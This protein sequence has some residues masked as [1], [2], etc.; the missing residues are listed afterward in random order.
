[1]K[2]GS[3]LLILAAVACTTLLGGVDAQ[4]FRMIQNSNPGRTSSGARVTC[5]DPGGFTHWTTATIAWRLNTADQGGAAGV[6]TALQ[7]AMTAWN[8]VSPASYTLGDAGTTNAGFV[9]DGINTVLWANGNGCTG[10]CLAITALVLAP[11]QVI[12]EADVSFNRSATWNTNGSDYDV[13]AVAAHELGHTLGI[14]HTEVRKPR[15]R[16]TMYAYYFGTAGRTLENDDRDALNCAYDRYPPAGAGLL[17]DR[18]VETLARPAD[19]AGVR[20]VARARPGGA[21][22]RF[23]LQTE[24]PVKLEVFDVAGRHLTTLVSGVRAAGEHEVAWDGTTG[25]GRVGSGVY[26]ARVVSP[27]G[28]ANATVILAE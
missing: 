21:I 28:K 7:A 25:F 26:F 19:Q 14:H 2:N 6:A 1:M 22:L 24:R 23:A 13:H 12:T 9:T 18:A 11:G 16:P 3:S 27:Q 15:D 4:A 8:G 10:S 20:L 17:A 5:D